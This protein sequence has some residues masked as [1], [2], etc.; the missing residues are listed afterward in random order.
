[1]TQSNAPFIVAAYVPCQTCGYACVL[2]HRFDHSPTDDELDRQVF[3]CACESCGET[4]V[5]VGRD[6]FKR[7]VVEWSLQ[8]RER[9][10]GDPQSG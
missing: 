2:V 6:A 9:P 1:M 7:T 8:G 3:R 5:R 4:Q 10:G